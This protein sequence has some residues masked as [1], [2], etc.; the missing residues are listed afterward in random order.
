MAKA[1]E[2]YERAVE[3][4]RAAMGPSHPL[5]C[6]SLLPLARLLRRSGRP[7]EALKMLQQQL[8]FMDAAG[9]HCSRGALPP[10]HCYCMRQVPPI[11]R[12]LT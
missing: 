1:Q 4:K 6:D 7:E 11:L 10:R 5:V 2:Y 9:Q 12:V 8:A 3:A